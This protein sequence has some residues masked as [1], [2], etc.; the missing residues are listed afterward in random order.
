MEDEKQAAQPQFD[1]WIATARPSDLNDLIP[2]GGLELHA[3]L[4]DGGGVLAYVWNETRLQTPRPATVEWV[5]ARRG[6]LAAFL[7]GGEVLAVAGGGDF[8]QHQPYSVAAWV[9]LPAND[10]SAALVARMDEGNNYRG[11]D[12]WVE[13]RRIGGHLIHQWPDNALK[14]VTAEPLPADE[15]V[16]V[17]L[18]YDGSQRAAGLKVFVNGQSQ[19]T[20]V[21]ADSLRGTTHTDVPLKIGMRQASSPLSGAALADV[22]VYDRAL[23]ADEVSTLAAASLI[24]D[25]AQLEPADRETMHQWW[26]THFDPV[27]ARLAAESE[28]LEREQA[29]IRRRGTLAYVM[30]ERDESPRAHVLRRGEYDQ[31]L[32]QVEPDTPGVLPSFPA[33]L[34]RNRLGLARWLLRDDHPLTARVT[35]N[36]FWQELFGLGLVRSAGDFGVSGELPSHPE[37]LDWLAIDFRASGWDVKRLFKMI[38]CSATYRQAAVVTPEKLERDPDNRLLSRGPRFRM[39]AEMIRDYALAASGLL[40]P[41]VG[42]PSVKPYQPPG[43]WEAVAM[44]VSNTRN[45]TQDT[46]ESLYR[47]SLYTFWK[48]AAPPASL[49]IFNAPNRE[50]CVVTRERTQTPLQALVTLND[51]QF[52]EAARHLAERALVEAGTASQDRLDFIA[53]R[54]LGR[55]LREEEAEILT[56]SQERLASFYTSRPAA[57]AELV[58]IG[59]VAGERIAASDRVGDL[60]DDRE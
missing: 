41:R 24:E 35:V 32:D 54:V 26:L 25:L 53:E 2:T 34:P 22:R 55:P 21:A 51:P 13:G 12:L 60:D 4:N 57:A 8:D 46:G 44:D 47:R 31:P 49:E 6:G 50:R 28:A 27:Y 29:D 20:N 33:D 15:W 11:W 43:V 59:A 18:V 56:A 1:A 40:S 17:T 30:Q 36:R 10:A 23:A 5:E 16:H 3:P 19:P 38:V 14:V 52:V 39:D 37:L 45:Y 42:G 9:K 58:Q 48:R 7:N